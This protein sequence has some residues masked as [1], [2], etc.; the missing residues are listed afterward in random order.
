MTLL[1]RMAGMVAACSLLSLT[2]AYAQGPTTLYACVNNNSGE[3]K[4]VAP[5]TLCK[6]NWTLEK[7]N[8]TGSQAT[9]TS[10]SLDYP[11]GIDGTFVAFRAG[12][13]NAYTVPT[14]KTLYL[15]AAGSVPPVVSGITYGTD[16]KGPMFPEGAV[17]TASQIT[18][19]TGILID[20]DPSTITPILLQLDNS[21]STYTVPAGSSLVVRSGW[22][23]GWALTVNGVPSSNQSGGIWVI[24]EG[25]TLGSLAPTATGYTGYLIHP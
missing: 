10:R 19:Y 16:G 9:P 15:S 7:W 18:T 22:G 3:V 11:Q 5:G 17:I 20:A 4:L 21:S 24:P 6:T 8:V 23:Q 2:V 12:S 14:G 1:R 25:N 13:G